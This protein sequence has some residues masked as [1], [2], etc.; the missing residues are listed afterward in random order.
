MMLKST[1]NRPL[2][3]AISLKNAPLNNGSETVMILIKKCPEKRGLKKR[4]QKH[5]EDFHSVF[6]MHFF[7][8]R[9]LDH[10]CQN[11]DHVTVIF[12]TLNFDANHDK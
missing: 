11:R 3:I 9:F 2:L 8:P 10:F 12:W 4:I 7:N 5:Y 1:R 6:W